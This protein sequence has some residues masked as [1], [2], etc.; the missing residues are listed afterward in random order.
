MKRCINLIETNRLERNNEGLNYM[1]MHEALKTR[2]ISEVI[3]IWA[4]YFAN[5]IQYVQQ[6]ANRMKSEFKLESIQYIYHISKYKNFLVNRFQKYLHFYDK[7]VASNDQQ[8]NKQ[9]SQ[10]QI[11][12]KPEFKDK[13]LPFD[14]HYIERQDIIY[15][16]CPQLIDSFHNG[17]YNMNS[18]LY[19]LK[20]DT[21]F[22][23]ILI[24]IMYSKQT[25]K[26]PGEQ[27]KQYDQQEFVQLAFYLQE[28]QN[29]FYFHSQ[30]Y[31]IVADSFLIINFQDEIQMQINFADYIENLKLYI[32]FMYFSCERVE[33]WDKLMEQIGPYT[34]LNLETEYYYSLLKKA[35]LILQSPYVSYDEINTSK[36]F[37]YTYIQT[38]I[39]EKDEDLEIYSMVGF[40]E[41]FI[42]M[43][44]WS[45]GLERLQ[46][47]FKDKIQ[48]KY[49]YKYIKVAIYMAKFFRFCDQFQKSLDIANLWLIQWRELLGEAHPNT[50]ELYGLIA[51]NQISL[52]FENNDTI[53]FLYKYLKLNQTAKKQFDEYYETFRTTKLAQNLQLSDE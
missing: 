34:Q 38:S 3:E 1:L 27:P 21:N 47:L 33:F 53:I 32:K 30:D 29:I 28:L 23:Q 5:D 24:N 2:S 11:I 26:D 17:D 10:T 49:E 6:I 40:A 39:Y 44:Q 16:K 31:S 41:S 15:V 45:Q 46:E 52:N 8:F 7:K 48:S 50:L 22:K 37:F 35:S 20:Y 13:A 36:E 14:S 12:S 25:Q 42:K 18:S 4:E 43:K 19:K 51:L 9:P